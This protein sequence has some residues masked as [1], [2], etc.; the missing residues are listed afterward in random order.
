MRYVDFDRAVGV[1]TSSAIVEMFLPTPTNEYETFLGV[2]VNTATSEID[3]DLCLKVSF[4]GT[5]SSV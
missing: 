4:L 2:S 3:L 1:S 5:V